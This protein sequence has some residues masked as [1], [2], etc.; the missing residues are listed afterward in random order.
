MPDY[1]TEIVESYSL[2]PSSSIFA[3]TD[4]RM[5]FV[6][7][8]SGVYKGFQLVEEGAITIGKWRNDKFIDGWFFVPFSL[9]SNK[10]GDLGYK[11]EE[12]I[13][14]GI[15]ENTNFE[16]A[17]IGETDFKGKYNKLKAALQ[18]YNWS[19]VIKK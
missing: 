1:K 12:A 19:K 10:D 3:V 5:Q 6:V 2:T 9:Y 13:L 8:E 7:N 17:Q 18:K 14:K 11:Y 4:E 16:H 15:N